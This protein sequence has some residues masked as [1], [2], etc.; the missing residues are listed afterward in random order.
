MGKTVAVTGINSYFASTVLPKLQADPE[1]DKIVGIDV[2]P[3]KGGYNKVVFHKIDIRNQEIFSILQGVEVVYHLAFV[4]GEI[5]DKEKTFDININ[6]SR[7]VFSACKKNK[8]KKVIYSSSATVYGSHENNPDV[9]YETSP[10]AKNEDN[11]YNSSKVEVEN[12]VTG[13]FKDSPDIILTVLRVALLFGPNINNM[14]SALF[15]LPVS[16][17]PPGCSN[18]SNQYIHEEDLG[19]ALYLAH[20]KDIP[21]TYNVG[22]DDSLGLLPAN[23]LA[24]VK[25]IPTPVLPLKIIAGIAFKI[26]LFP[27]G[28]GWVSMA[29]HPIF[30]NSDK[31]KIATG[32]KPKYNSEETFRSFLKGRER[33]RKD[34][35]FYTAL[36][37]GFRQSTLLVPFFKVLDFI[38]RLGK[39]PWLRTRLSWINPEKNSMTYLPVNQSLKKEADTVLPPQILFDFIDSASVFFLLDSCGCRRAHKCQNFTSDAGCL[40][41]GPSALEL[42]AGI[43]HLITKEKAREHAEKAIDLGLVPLT[44]KVRV[45]NSLFFVKDKQQLLTICFCCHCCCMM[46]SLKHTPGKQLDD[47]MTHVEGL[48]IEVTDACTGCGT[49][50]ETCIFNAI[51]IENGQAVHTGQCRGCGRCERYCPNKAITISVDNPQFIEDVKKRI[52]TYVDFV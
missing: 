51:T 31:F 48:S 34:G 29:K 42:P 33:D 49:C 47:V 40:F 43:G 15:S 4:V 20:K 38:F 46:G 16:M 5:Q 14:F 19:E 39:V 11:Y 17:L 37:V 1:I 36:A 45:D 3:W 27:A 26:G 8:I 12:F 7:N 22:A 2:T 24:H 28:S 50:I 41:L 25:I 6:G 32:W 9:F 44:G 18:S 21:G 35:L 30:I 52:E 13:F 23:K 10:L